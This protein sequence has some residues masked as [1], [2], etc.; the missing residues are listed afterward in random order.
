MAS[1]KISTT[2]A[3]VVTRSETSS[4]AMLAPARAFTVA[5]ATGACDVVMPT[6]VQP[7]ANANTGSS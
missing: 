4:S 6:P 3:W 7:F 1:R 2:P 5:G